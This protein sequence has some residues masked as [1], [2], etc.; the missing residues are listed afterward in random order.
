MHSCSS[1]YFFSW[2]QTKEERIIQIK[3]VLSSF[4]CYLHQTSKGSYF[5]HSLFFSCINEIYMIIWE[6]SL[7]SKQFGCHSFTCFHLNGERKLNKMKSSDSCMNEVMS[8]LSFSQTFHHSHYCS[9]WHIVLGKGTTDKICTQS[10]SFN[11]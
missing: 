3:V 1:D 2:L 6:F 4:S 7:I 5:L 8:I 11:F 10:M 9:F